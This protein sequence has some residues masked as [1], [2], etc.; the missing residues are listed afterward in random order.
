MLPQRALTTVALASIVAAVATS[1][2]A[3]GLAPSDE[4]AKTELRVGTATRPDSLNPLVASNRL[5]RILASLLYDE[6]LPV[7][8]DGEPLPGLLRNWKPSGDGRL[9]LLE[10]RPGLRWSDGRLVNARDVVHTLRRIKS[11]PRSRFSRW[12]DGVTLIKRFNRRR[13]GIRLAASSD[14]PPVLPIPLLPRHIWSSVQPRDVAAFANDPPIGSGVFGTTSPS[15]DGAIRLSALE[16]H[17][18]GELAIDELTVQFYESQAT[19][20][21]ALEAGQI[22]VA[23]DLAP[24]QA[25]FLEGR[26][27]IE[28]RP[29]PPTAFV[30]LGMN[31]GSTEGDGHIAL[32]EARVRRAIAFALDREELRELAL[33]SYGVAGSTIVPPVLPQH[34]GPTAE[35]EI[36]L[37]VER[38]RELLTRAGLVDADQ[39]G[40]REANLGLPLQLRLYTRRSLPETQRLGERIVVALGEIGIDVLLSE[41]TD[42][43]L[44]QRL[45]G[46]RYDLFI[47]GWDVGSDPSFIAS[48][49]SCGEALPT[50]LSDTYFCDPEYDDLYNRYVAT[51]S[52]GERQTLLAAIQMRAYSRAPY[53]VLYYRPTFQAFRSDRFEA[54]DDESLPIVFAP[55]PARPI[56]LR[57]RPA[58][59]PRPPT[60][61]AEEGTTAVA[62]T[63]GLLD[64]IRSSL[65]WRI[66]AIAG[67]AVVGLLLLPSA[68]RLLRWVIRIGKKDDEGEA[69]DVDEDGVEPESDKQGGTDTD[70][71]ADAPC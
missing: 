15:E 35:T 10:L 6:L 71:S 26:P 57:L 29:T 68:L 40:V 9:W 1:S 47:W 18:R 36:T 30:S 51:T 12:L 46:G 25:Q 62:P 33:G 27:S 14:T 50:G 43:E 17:W 61:A 70:V 45:R 42:R 4:A 32:R 38:A 64:E 63:T 53:V 67:L 54:S 34:V 28:V 16:T 49:L 56:N 37:D 5:G 11:D 31:T 69:S 60:E 22:D 19:L 44:T 8:A 2:A 20:V 23:D 21:E 41:L 48:V 7:D 24:E 13:V 55:P 65:L 59:P 66:L 58:A 52:Q 39:D 3:A